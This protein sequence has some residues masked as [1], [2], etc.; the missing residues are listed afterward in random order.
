MK[1]N[2]VLTLLLFTSIFSFGQQ[3]IDGNLKELF[4]AELK[5]EII[6]NAVLQVYSKSKGINIQLFEKELNAEET[7][8]ANSPFYTASITKMLTATAIGILN[9]RKLLSFNDTIS[10]YLPDELLKGLHVF[11]G[12]EY[13]KKITIAHLLQH[14]SGL[15]DYFEDQ[16]TNG[17]PNIISQLFITPDKIWTPKAIIE[18]T[19]IN[20]TPHFIPGKGYHYT[21][22]E[23]VL[24]GL[25]IEK[26]S[27]LKLDAFFKQEIFKPL[28][29]NQSYINLKS[30]PINKTLP[31]MKFYASDTEISSLQSLSADWSGGG[32]VATTKDL[33]RFLEAFNKNKIVKNDTRLQMQNWEPETYGMDYGF[34]VRKVSFKKLMNQNTNLTV[35]G[36]SGSTASFLWYCPQ[37]DTY[38]SGTLN[39]TEAN[40]NALLMVFK[41]LNLIQKKY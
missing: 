25:I 30:T 21:D 10:K 35:I 41:I 22:T 20:M 36:H 8:E 3:T 5:N 38:V 19:K 14:T 39:Q 12:K 23:Y 9:D 1:N 31:L 33:I 4:K 24:L 16:T 17:T 40:K 26:V 27:G 15:P 28:K 34:G 13:S 32:L 29:M 7:V 2:L 11:E 6:S 18:F 37:T